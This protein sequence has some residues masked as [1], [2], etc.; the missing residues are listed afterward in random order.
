MALSAVAPF[1]IHLEDGVRGPVLA[2]WMRALARRDLPLCHRIL[3]D[4]VVEPQPL[5]GRG[6]ARQA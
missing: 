6:V 5:A 3:A 1:L 2:A 4:C